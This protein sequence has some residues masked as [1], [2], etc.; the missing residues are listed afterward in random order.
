MPVVEVYTEKLE[1][2]PAVTDQATKD[3]ATVVKEDV[4]LLAPDSRA[5]SSPA[6]SSERKTSLSDSLSP[7]PP[8]FAAGLEDEIAC[9]SQAILS[10]SFKAAR[11]AVRQ[12]WRRCLIGSKD[13][14]PE[15]S[16]SDESYLVRAILKHGNSYVLKRVIEEYGDQLLAHATEDTLHKLMLRHG[17]HLLS[18]AP[19]A[20]L[21]RAIEMRLPDI[22][23]DDLVKMLAKADR[24]GYSESDLVD[25]KDERVGVMPH[26]LQRVQE[27]DDSDVMEVDPPH[28]DAAARD[29]RT[30]TPSEASKLYFAPPLPESANYRPTNLSQPPPPAASA[31]TLPQMV[32]TSRG[33]PPNHV[34][35]SKHVCPDCGGSFTQSA[36]LRYVGST[37]C[38]RR[39]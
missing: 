32:L 26:G 29:D 24:L 34:P 28:P 10:V 31:S 37:P 27:S 8:K 13:E 17:E 36:G 21:D 3:L 25:G 30:G 11:S 16:K 38:S 6:I 14:T 23:A 18:V 15:E 19:E 4:K 5:A 22:D 39:P 35:G 20:V 33:K 9:V 1:S 2:E 7:K 12:N